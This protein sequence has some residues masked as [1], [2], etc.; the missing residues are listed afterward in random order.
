MGEVRD[1]GMRDQERGRR[2]RRRGKRLDIQFL[3]SEAEN[4]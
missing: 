3:P 1:E 2:D 4:S